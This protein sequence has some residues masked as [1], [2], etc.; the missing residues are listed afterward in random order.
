MPVRG[1]YRGATV[2]GTVSAANAPIYIDSDDN[3]LKFIPAGTGSTE[4]VALAGIGSAAKV[5]GGSGALVSGASVV[6]TGLASVLGF[7]WNIVGA[8]GTGA[9][10]AQLPTITS[11]TTG[12]V[13]IT[14]YYVST[15]GA[16]G[17]TVIASGSAASYYWTAVG[18]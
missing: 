7:S 18:T 17:A 15:I 10:N 3:L 4:V 11:I 8:T 5:A 2:K 12:A 1:L 14:A 6:A 9:A 13:T 16:S